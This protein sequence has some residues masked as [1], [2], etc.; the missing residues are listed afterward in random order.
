MY[1]LYQD[2]ASV[3][4]TAYVSH[5]N[6]AQRAALVSEFYGPQYSLTK[7]RPA[8]LFHQFCICLAQSNNA[9][10]SDPQTGGTSP[11]VFLAWGFG[12][13]VCQIL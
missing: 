11:P 6:S 2:A 8:K 12:A 5:A 3:L 4:E 7:V 13:M 9:G 10:K 1:V